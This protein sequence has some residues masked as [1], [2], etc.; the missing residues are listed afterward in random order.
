MANIPDDHERFAGRAGKQTMGF[1][2]SRLHCTP[3]IKRLGGTL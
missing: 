3:Q 2:Y 1:R